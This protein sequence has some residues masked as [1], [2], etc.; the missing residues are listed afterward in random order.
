[1]AENL[2]HEIFI[3]L[4][5]TQNPEVAIEVRHPNTVTDRTY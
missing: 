2:L 4:S 5:Y 1:M 3:G